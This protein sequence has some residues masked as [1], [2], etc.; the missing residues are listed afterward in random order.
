MS[1]KHFSELPKCTR[2]TP[3]S[4]KAY[5]HLQ[6]LRQKDLPSSV[7]TVDKLVIEQSN[8]REYRKICGFVD[9]GRVPATYFAVLS[10]TL[11]M[12]MM[13]KPDFPFAMLGLVHVENSVTQHRV[14]LIPKQYAYRCVLIIFALMIRVSSL[15]L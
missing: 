5:Y 10:Q 9:D 13:A 8:L 1:D 12:N 4:S 7:Y 11:Q 3:M 2:P 15:I 14:I 6:T